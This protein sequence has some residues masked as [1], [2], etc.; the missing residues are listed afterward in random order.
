[1]GRQTAGIGKLKGLFET[2]SVI[3]ED[4]IKNKRKGNY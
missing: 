3:W 4:N 1:M 2:I